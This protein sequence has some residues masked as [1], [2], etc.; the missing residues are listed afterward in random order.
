MGCRRAEREGRGRSDATE[1][2]DDGNIPPQGPPAPP[3]SNAP[4][5][6]DQM[7]AA[8]S[9]IR[10]GV[11]REVRTSAATAERRAGCPWLRRRRGPRS[12]RRQARRRSPLA[13]LRARPRHSQA[14]GPR[15]RPPPCARNRG[16]DLHHDHG[17]GARTT[18]DAAAGVCRRTRTGREPLAGA[19]SSQHRR[20]AGGRS[21]ERSCSSGGGAR[22][23]PGGV[24]CGEVGRAR[25]GAADDVLR[26]HVAREASE[27][28]QDRSATSSL[29]ASQ[30]PSS[31]SNGSY[32]KGSRV[33]CRSA[34]GSDRA[35]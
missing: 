2:A 16:Q 28:L 12:C 30:V 23:A 11:A 3:R 34:H 5:K 29:R 7:P 27:V 6:T 22:R 20:T 18:C 33:C 21:T 19:G 9:T 25:H 1:C 31:R 8:S 35:S 14:I 24:E 13:T 10:K 26:T 4:A 32:W 15:D 17:R